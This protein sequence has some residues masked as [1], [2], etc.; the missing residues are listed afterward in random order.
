MP[1][2]QRLIDCKQPGKAPGRSKLALAILLTVLSQA[3]PQ[4]AFSLESWEKLDKRLKSQ[5]LQLNVGLKMKVKDSLWVQLADLSPKHKFPVF[6][7][8]TQDRGFRV[9]GFG[10]CFPIKGRL[11]DKSYFVTNKHVVDTADQL[12]K[13]CQLFYA[14][15]HLY[16]EQSAGWGGNPENRFKEILQIVNVASKKDRTESELAQYRQTVN[17]IWDTYERHLS[18]RV[19]PKRTAFNKHLSQA[20]VSY[21]LGYFLHPPGAVTQPPLVGK[22]YKVAKGEGEPDLAILTVDKTTIPPMEL[23]TVAP[24]EGQE[25]QVIGY[26]MASDQIDAD[27][28]KYYAP[29]FSTGRVSRVA[30][31]TLQ[32][33]A[34]ITTGNSGGPVVNQRGKVIGVV[35]RR[36]LSAS[37][38]ELTNFGAAVTA[39]GVK[40]FAPELFGEN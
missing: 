15:M 36:A 19:D 26:P 16:A 33:D 37:G 6:S 31:R 34:P 23:D 20:L 29:T 24:S 13:E 18:T 1:G 32:V 12:I 28:S 30:P 39:A 9:V 21:E 27:S 40:N 10:T 8:S 3:V 2:H 5:V 4:A 11:K 7:S 35:A 14:G 25:I 17:D 22:L 38:S